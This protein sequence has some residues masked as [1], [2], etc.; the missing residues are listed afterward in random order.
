MSATP[1]EAGGLR[2][3][4]ILLA[5]MISD[6][7]GMV[8]L[9]VTF[10]PA[11]R[12][13]GLSELEFGVLVA[14]ANI[15]LGVA[16][17][18]WGRR[19]QVLGRRPV[20]V[21]GLS[22]F[23]AGFLGLGLVLDA[24]LAGWLAPLPLFALLLAARLGYG[25]VA[26]AT[27]PAATAW[28]ADVTPAETRTRGMALIGIAAG[29]GTVLGPVL[30]GSLAG[31]GAVTPLYVAAGMAAAA[32]VAAWGGLG[33]PARHLPALAAGS[34]RDEQ[35]PAG[36][37]RFTDP[38]ILPWLAGWFVLVVVLTGTQTV[39]VFL[40][41]DRFLMESREAI[42]QATSVAFL[43]MGAAML[44]MQAGVL[45][46]FRIPPLPLVRAGFALFAAALAVLMA[47]PNLATLAVAYALLGL[48]SSALSAGLNAA[49]TLSVGRE[50][51][52]AVAGLLAAAPVAGMIIGPVL[53]PGLYQLDPL[54]PLA[55][56]VVLCGAMGVWFWRW[57]R[58]GGGV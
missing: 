28:I 58:V 3:K 56:G 9:F 5:G 21:I 27:Q 51:Q 31:L 48:G 34:R 39:T 50:E 55:L 46:V 53:A 22:G 29:L 57:R 33:E 37:L 23:A 15:T 14:A 41:A 30:G 36:H 25:L 40:V 11:A 2:D 47:A 43:A 12:Q 24:G 16:S 17:P 8:L 20:F 38:R 54:A 26:A 6:R 10:G 19:S 42:A 52:G 13:L 18:Y 35:R 7:I 1:R 4:A 49:G 32:A 44:V 45:Q